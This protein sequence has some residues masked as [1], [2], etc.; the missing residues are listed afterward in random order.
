MQ[1]KKLFGCFS[2]V[3]A[4]FICL[5]QPGSIDLSFDPG[6]GANGAVYSLLVQP[7]GRV[8]I[9]GAFTTFDGENRSGVARLNADGS[10]DQ[11]FDPGFGFGDGAVARLALQ[12]DGKVIAVGSFST[13]NGV[14]RDRIAR[15][16]ADGSLDVVYN[17]VVEFL[18]APIA[19]ALQADGK[20]LIHGMADNGSRLLRL[21]IDGSLDGSFAAPTFGQ[22]DKVHSIAVSTDGKILIA[23]LQLNQYG[24]PTQACMHRMNANG[25]LDASFVSVFGGV[26]WQQPPATGVFDCSIL[27]SGE[28][29]VAGRFDTYGG[30][31]RRALARLQAQGNV[32]G[33]WS[34]TAPV[35][36]TIRSMVVQPNGKIIVAFGNCTDMFALP[37]LGVSSSVVNNISRFA[38]DGSLDGAFDSATDVVDVYDMALQSDGKILIV[39]DFSTY[40]NV[41][42]IRIARLNG[43]PTNVAISEGLGSDAQAA[44]LFPNPYHG[45]RLD[46]RFGSVSSGVALVLVIDATGKVMLERM[47]PIRTISRGL[48]EVSVENADVL[49]AGVYVV[50][51]TTGREQ[52]NQRLVIEP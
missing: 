42:R 8:L 12:S 33:E 17:P 45:G 48:V 32:D 5:A 11:T 41:P 6:D 27:G 16:N 37:A 43:D 40:N 51:T 50:R 23:G 36:S 39:G 49:P 10:L 2:S 18:H 25:D 9:C 22:Y 7:D 35:S 44:M 21:N 38:P 52:L 46:T 34:S 28:I 31:P 13:F 14:G 47:T 15:L 26:D 29:L 3:V 1:I 30:S 4:S 20:A 19:V 24:T